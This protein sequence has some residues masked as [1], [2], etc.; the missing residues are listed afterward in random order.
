[1]GKPKFPAEK[2]IEIIE[3]FQRGE[4]AWSQLNEVY[5]IH[6]NTIY[7]WIPRYEANGIAGFAHTSLRKGRNHDNINQLL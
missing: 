3:A 4:V 7:K 2:M 5:G 1:M 6:P